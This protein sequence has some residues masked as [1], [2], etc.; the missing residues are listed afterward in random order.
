MKSHKKGANDL[1][2][3]PSRR[4]AM[5]FGRDHNLS[6]FELIKGRCT[7]KSNLEKEATSIK[8]NCK[9]GDIYA[10]VIEEVIRGMEGGG[11]KHMNSMFQL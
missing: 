4:L 5:L 11:N 3:H 2:I 8:F 6:R 7:I 9:E 1:S 10:I